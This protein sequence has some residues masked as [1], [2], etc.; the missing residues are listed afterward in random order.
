MLGDE[1]QKKKRER[2]QEDRVMITG[3]CRRRDRGAM[4]LSNTYLC[5][6]KENLIAGSAVY[7]KVI[8]FRRGRSQVLCLALTGLIIVRYG[9]YAQRFGGTLRNP[10]PFLAPISATF[11]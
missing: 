11:S 9:E 6:L 5:P 10:L 1:Q 4:L 7:H 2:V 3:P 8:L